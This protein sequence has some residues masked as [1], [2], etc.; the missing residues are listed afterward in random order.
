MKPTLCL[1]AFVMCLGAQ[2]VK[3]TTATP[4]TSSGGAELYMRYC[5]ACHGKDGKGGGPAAKAMKLPPT[6]L[7][8]LAKRNGGKYPAIQVS[9]SITGDGKIVPAH[10]SSEMPVWGE[11]LDSLSQRNPAEAKLRIANLTTYIGTLQAK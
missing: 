4:P 8:T 6:D 7:T 5:A 11:I 1:V 9:S 3:K 10:G 2:T